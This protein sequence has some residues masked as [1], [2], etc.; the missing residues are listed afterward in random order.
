M[1]LT[2]L[3]KRAFENIVGKEENACDQHFLLFPCFL[4]YQRCK[5][6]FELLKNCRLPMLSIWTSVKFCHLVEE[7]NLYQTTK[8][9]TGQS[10][11][12]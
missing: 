9:W 3:K 12:R 1:T 5:S 2:T 8:F 10:I 4:L 7:L 6:S 11:C